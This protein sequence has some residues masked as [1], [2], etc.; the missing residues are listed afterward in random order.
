[1]SKFYSKNPNFGGVFMFFLKKHGVKTR[2][3]LQINK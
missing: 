2:L 3:T 1:M